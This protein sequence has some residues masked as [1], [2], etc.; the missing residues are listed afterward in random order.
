MFFG[1]G[2]KSLPM[3]QI[4]KQRIMILQ[5]TSTKSHFIHPL[6]LVGNRRGGERDCHGHLLPK[7]SRELRHQ[8]LRGDFGGHRHDQQSFPLTRHHP[9]R[10][11][12]TR[13]SLRFPLQRSDYLN[14]ADCHFS[15]VHATLLRV[16]QS[17]QIQNFLPL[18]CSKISKKQTVKDGP[19][20]TVTYR[21]VCT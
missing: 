14:E 8:H 13:N 15:R 6:L 16:S 9:F 1:G 20:D 2:A 4:M 11:F 19:T 5:K 7:Q 17:A 12:A 18:N 10:N 3:T 21:V